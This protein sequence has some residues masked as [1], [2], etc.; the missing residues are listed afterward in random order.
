MLT[1]TPRT[2]FRRG[3]NIPAKDDSRLPLLSLSVTQSRVA[4]KGGAGG[5][6]KNETDVIRVMRKSE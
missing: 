4:G 2:A 1:A 6:M 5:S 3:G